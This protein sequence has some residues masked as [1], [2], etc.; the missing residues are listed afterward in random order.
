MDRF[1]PKDAES[2]RLDNGPLPPPHI[3]PTPITLVP[4][5]CMQENRD[6]TVNVIRN[7][8]R[9]SRDIPIPLKLKVSGN[10]M[11]G[12]ENGNEKKRT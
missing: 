2:I 11:E 8:V 5:A 10:K 9:V 6:V 4:P 12:R 3:R 1:Y 7:S